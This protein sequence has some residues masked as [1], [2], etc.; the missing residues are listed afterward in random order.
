[1]LAL[2]LG[3]LFF[4]SIYPIDPAQRQA[5]VEQANSIINSTTGQTP[6]G[7]F[8]AISENNIRVAL[9]EMVPVVGILLFAFSIFTTGQ[10]IQALALS[11]GLP[12]PLFGAALFIFPFAIVELSAYAVAV[13]SG[14]MLIV[15]WRR[16]RLRGELRVFAIEA[17]IVVAA[18]LI[19]A[20]MET[21][22]I[23]DP[24]YSFSLW[25]P[26]AL[27]LAALVFFVRGRSR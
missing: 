8:S 5:L 21:A 10:V 14:L 9:V 16:K 23:L 11:Q 24:I 7:V 19:A 26:T 4:A 22:G 13:V 1:V 20:A 12:G 25:L 18:I 3:L 27:G 17:S 6:T 15:A 2:E